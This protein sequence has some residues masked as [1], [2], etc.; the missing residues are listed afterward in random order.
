M[1]ETKKET[2]TKEKVA[3]A[4]AIENECCKGP[5]CCSC[6]EEIPEEA[7]VSPVAGYYFCDEAVMD[8]E[9]VPDIPEGYSVVETEEGVF[10]APDISEEDYAAM[11]FTPMTEE[12]AEAHRKSFEE[13]Y[14]SL[15]DEEV[16]FLANSAEAVAAGLEEAAACYDQLTEREKLEIFGDPTFYSVADDDEDEDCEEKETVTYERS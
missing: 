16:E 5:N 1:C 15:S 10:M 9:Y 2:I 12:E 14:N 13:Y 7:S 8:P 6:A 11:G 3:S 4:A